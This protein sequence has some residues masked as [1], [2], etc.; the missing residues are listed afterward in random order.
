LGLSFLELHGAMKKK[1]PEEY[2]KKK[3]EKNE[4]IIHAELLFFPPDYKKDDNML[5]GTGVERGLETWELN[6][7][8]FF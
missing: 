4:K 8:V 1:T 3:N 6:N 5:D 7:T 2:E